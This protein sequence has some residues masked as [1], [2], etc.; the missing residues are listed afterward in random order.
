M[1]RLIL[2]VLIAA[3]LLCLFP[4]AVIV[5]RAEQRPCLKFEELSAA[6]VAQNNGVSLTAIDREKTQN[7][8]KRLA[9]SNDVFAKLKGEM[10]AVFTKPNGINVVLITFNKLGCADQM[11]PVPARYFVSIIEEKGI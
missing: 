5:A 1:P 2:A 7:F 3:A 8:L 9:D 4:V 6:T 11:M 10:V